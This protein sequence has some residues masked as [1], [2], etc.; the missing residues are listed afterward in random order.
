MG[1]EGPLRVGGDQYNTFSRDTVGTAFCESVCDARRFEV[2]QI[3]IAVR[4]LCHLTAHI[5]RRAHHRGGNHA[6]AGAAS[7]GVVRLNQVIGKR[8]QY[9]AL[10]RLIDQGHHAFLYIHCCQFGVGHLNF[11]IDQCRTDGICR[12]GFHRVCPVSG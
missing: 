2:G 4:I 3:N 6:I 10:T 11:G 8:R 12:I 7:G 9:V 5:G 1:I